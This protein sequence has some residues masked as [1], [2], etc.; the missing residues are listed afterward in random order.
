LFSEVGQRGKD[1]YKKKSPGDVGQ[2]GKKKS[3]F[4]RQDAWTF[5]FNWM[6]EQTKE[7]VT[8]GEG[9]LKESCG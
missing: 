3:F 9:N 8:L 5:S 4:Q 7:K 1:H 6:S 2:Q